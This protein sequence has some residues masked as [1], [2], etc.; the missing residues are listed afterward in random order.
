MTATA[1]SLPDATQRPER[2]RIAVV[3]SRFPTVT[4]TFI[5]REF[6]EMEKQ[7]QPVRLV[8][9]IRENPPFLHDAA[10]P[11]TARALYTP[12]LSAKIALANLATFFRNPFKY[13]SLLA[14]LIAG[15]LR[16][17]RGLVR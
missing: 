7:V 10:K 3:L 15:T 4:E 1:Q 13:V 8:P 16:Y 17:P 2:K 9:M 12:F 6:V 11:W 14:R 5:L